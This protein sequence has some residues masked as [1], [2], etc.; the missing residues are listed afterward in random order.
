M[1]RLCPLPAFAPAR[2]VPALALALGACSKPSTEPAAPPSAASPPAAAPVASII[3]PPPTGEGETSDDG[4]SGEGA[5][6]S[7]GADADRFMAFVKERL[8]TVSEDVL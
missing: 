6:Q 2:F 4:A 5:P 3:A 1:T 7:D 8:E